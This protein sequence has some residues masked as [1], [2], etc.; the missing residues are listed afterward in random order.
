ML[1]APIENRNM[2]SETVAAKFPIHLYYVVIIHD[3]QAR[4][5]PQVPVPRNKDVNSRDE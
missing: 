2:T 3:L 1:S 4:F 5:F